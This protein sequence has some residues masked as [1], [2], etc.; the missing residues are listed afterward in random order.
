MHIKKWAIAIMTGGLV[1]PFILQVN[2][3]P[4]FRFGMFAEA[5]HREIQTEQFQIYTIDR[6]GSRKLLQP[7]EV[8]ISKSNWDYLLRNHYYR[9]E[10]VVFLKKLRTL[11]KE[12][13]QFTTLQMIRI[14]QSDSTI[15]YNFELK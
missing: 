10:N 5:V 15:V 11:M 6:Q 3:Y 4:F 9:N 7:D 12:P 8:G 13:E 1:L 2:I 14:I